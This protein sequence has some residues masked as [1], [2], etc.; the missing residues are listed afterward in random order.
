MF[1]TVPKVKLKTLILM[2]FRQVKLSKSTRFS[3]I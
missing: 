1:P 2:Y 3:K